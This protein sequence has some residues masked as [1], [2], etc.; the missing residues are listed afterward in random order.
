[1]CTLASS[2]LSLTVCSPLFTGVICAGPS[3]VASCTEVRGEGAMDFLD[4]RFT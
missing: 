4:E 3:R 2:L 1:M